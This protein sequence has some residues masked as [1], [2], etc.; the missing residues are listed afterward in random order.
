MSHGRGSGVSWP[1]WWWWGWSGWDGS[2]G[3]LPSGAVS[4]FS[5]TSHRCHVLS[6]TLHSR[7]FAEAVINAAT[8]TSGITYRCTIQDSWMGNEEETDR[9]WFLC[10]NVNTKRTDPLVP[11][12]LNT[13][14][15]ETSLC[16]N[17]VKHL[18]AG[19]SCATA[20]RTISWSTILWKSYHFSP[21]WS[22]L[23]DL[24]LTFP[25]RHCQEN[26]HIAW[27][28]AGRQDGAGQK[29]EIGH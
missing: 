1:K 6:V 28:G 25:R 12:D 9:A 15:S 2:G 23:G 3:G 4:V 14:W 20:S 18:F 17:H 29:K 22:S 26:F 27:Q 21:W 5:W 8:H 7:D 13:S 10:G 11:W 24:P 16:N 19:N